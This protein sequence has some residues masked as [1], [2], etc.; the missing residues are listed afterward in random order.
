M[1]ANDCS[2]AYDMIASYSQDYQV[3]DKMKEEHEKKQI[4]KAI[5]KLC[6]KRTIVC[7]YLHDL[8]YDKVCISIIGEDYKK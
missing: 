4:L 3:A 7:K 1:Y 8:P 5:S 2:F 6:Y